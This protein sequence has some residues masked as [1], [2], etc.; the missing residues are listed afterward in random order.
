MPSSSEFHIFRDSRRRTCASELAGAVRESLSALGATSL[1]SLLM[2]LLQSGELECALSDA[3]AATEACSRASRLTDL[4]ADAAIAADADDP[5]DVRQILT[6]ASSLLGKIQFSGDLSV[7]VPEGFAYYALHPLDYA[8]LVERSQGEGGPAIV[9][10]IRSIGTTLSAVVAAKLRWTKNRNVREARR[11]GCPGSRDFRGPAVSSPGDQS[12][13]RFTVRPTGHPY[14]RQCVFDPA[15]RAH[16]AEGLA[17]GAMFLVCDEGPGR[18]G[19]SLLSVAEALEQEG[20]ARSRIVILCAYE[21]D[22]A[23]LCA[24]DAAE[25]W[26]RYRVL[27]AGVTQRLPSDA[28]EYLGGGEWRKKSFTSREKCPALWPQMERLRYGSPDGRR[29]LSFEGHGPYGA[30]VRHRQQALSD[31]GFGLPYL[32][33]DAGFGR[34]ELLK[35]RLSRGDDVSNHLLKHMAEYCAWRA[36]EF[37]V[38][39][40][41]V[42]QLETMARVN[43]EREFGT[44]ADLVLS[45]ERPTVCD[46]RMMPHEW[47]RADDGRWV[48]LNAAIH[49]DDH[50]FPGPCDIAWD[51]A[52]A[53]VEWNLDESARAY[54]LS[55]YRRVSGDDPTRR[56]AAYES[57]YATF[58]MAWSGMAAGSVS[59]DGEKGRLIRDYREYRS[60]LGLRVCT[61]ARE[62]HAF[63]SS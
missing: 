2:P 12:V 52:G 38:S 1:D 49:G 3:A 25:R 4:F 11:A 8:D 6:T 21:P 22:V 7:S 60:Y 45:L 34:H 36:R 55:E 59:D 53:I 42:S 58:R 27:A 54:L 9:I 46:A 56:I 5:I 33:Q 19:S 28:T 57:A 48:K 30:A 35:G 39:N 44:P 43:Y 61:A 24:R 29:L 14:D 41:D 62:A 31:A 26:S 47:L 23:A 40:A 15:Q 32:G 13:R 10:G 50:F 51:L 20:V 63:T 17:L 18:S 37:A 16:I